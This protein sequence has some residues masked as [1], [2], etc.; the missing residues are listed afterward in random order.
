MNVSVRPPKDHPLLI[1]EERLRAECR[2]EFFK[3]SGPGGQHRN[4]VE[5]AVRITHSPTG[6]VGEASERRSQSENRAA[7]WNRLRLNLALRIRSR[8]ID[9]RKSGIEF[10]HPSKSNFTDSRSVWDRYRSGDR[11]RISG[12]NPDFPIVLMEF[13]D[14]WESVGHDWKR[15][16]DEL[17]TTKSQLLRLIGKNSQASQTIQKGERGEA[18]ERT[19][20]KKGES[21]LIGLGANLGD[22]K[23]N[24]ETAW[25]RIG[26]RDEIT[27]VALSRFL[28]TIPVGGPPNQPNFLNAVGLIE[29]TLAALD[30]LDVLTFIEKE[31]GRERHEF[32]GAR[33]VD[34]DLLLYGDQIIRSRRLTVPHPRMIWR[35]FVLIP[36]REIAPGLRHPIFDRTMSE[37]AALS[38]MNLRL[39]G[40]MFASPF[41]NGLTSRWR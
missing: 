29:T 3:G 32:W 9:S 8:K 13:L 20:K 15:S 11:I 12:D 36:A 19:L 17:S 1:P 40:P 26:E 30:L 23:K 6:I 2:I 33:T 27:P 31:G 10:S 21:V 5:T 35:P 25:R 22:R 18:G 34:L 37:L 28:E 24:L 14:V 38:E 39:G 16:A 4:K 41:P 7:A